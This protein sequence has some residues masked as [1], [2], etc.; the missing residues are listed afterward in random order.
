MW[1]LADVSAEESLV[2]F[3]RNPE[4]GFE[5]VTVEDSIW[6]CPLHVFYT[7]DCDSDKIEPHILETYSKS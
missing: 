7:Q 6:D 3:Y 2:E 1:L 5:E 4:F